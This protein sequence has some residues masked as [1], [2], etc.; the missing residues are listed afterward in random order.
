MSLATNADRLVTQVLGGEVWPPLA[1]RH[2]YRIDPDGNPFILPGMG[3]VSRGARPGSDATGYASDHLEPGLSIRHA[4]AEANAA[5]Q[6]LS[7]VGN[8]VTVRTGPA[9]GATG[10]VIGQHAYVLADFDDAAL[11]RITTGD[12]VSIEARGQGLRLL[13]HDRI[14]VK[15]LDPELLERLPVSTAP[16]GAL[17]V[18]VAV[19]VPAEAAGAGGGML[20]EFANTDLMGAYPGLSDDLSLGLEGLRIG[21]LVVLRDQDHGYGRGFR[22]G[23]LTIGVIST[24]ECRL[25]GHGPGPSTLFSGPAEAFRLVFDRSA[26]LGEILDVPGAGSPATPSPSSTTTAEAD[27]A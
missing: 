12:V 27:R 2:G 5:L 22:P 21:D 16:D 13:D 14:R 7:C 8:R 15:N 11:A 4:D 20:S 1:D 19:D 10:V 9:A 3:G 18:T 25:F 17:E 6:F 23:W 26:N 24:G